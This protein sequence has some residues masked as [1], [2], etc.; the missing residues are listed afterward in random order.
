LV[1]DLFQQPFL[2]RWIFDVEILARLI[3]RTRGKDIPP[4]DRLIY[5]FPLTEWRDVAGSKVQLYDFT[6]AALELYRIRRKYFR[7]RS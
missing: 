4:A 7:S 2:S 6:K 5:E 3:K 1:R